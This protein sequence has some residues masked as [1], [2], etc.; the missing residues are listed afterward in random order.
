MYKIQVGTKNEILR[1]KIQKVTIFDQKLK[2]IV[3]DMKKIMTSPEDNKKKGVGLAANQIGLDLQILLV[4][5]NVGTSKK[6]KIVTM[7]NPE[8]L[9]VYSQK[10]IMEEGCLSLPNEK[11]RKI[12]RVAKIKVRWQ[13][14]DGN[15]CEKKLTKW[16]ARI[17]LHEYDHLQGV[18]YIDY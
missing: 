13:N 15:F 9:E 11:T 4:T 2:K 7:I 18:L 8:I 17:F 10:V 3:D 1:K 6:Q 14:L 16:D 5:F 12:S